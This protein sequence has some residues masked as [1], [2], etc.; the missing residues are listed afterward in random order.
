MQCL[1]TRASC[2]PARGSRL[3][4]GADRG[5]LGNVL[6]AGAVADGNLP[7]LSPGAVVLDALE[8]SV[9]ERDTV[10]VERQADAVLVLG[11]KGIAGE[12]VLARILDHAAKLQVHVDHVGVDTALVQ[13]GTSL[14]VGAE[15]LDGGLRSNIGHDLRAGR[16]GLGG[17]VLAVQVVGRVD[18][19]VVGLNENLLLGGV[20]RASEGNDLLALVGDGVGG[21]DNVSLV[22]LKD[23]LARVGGDL[24]EVELGLVT[25][26]VAGQE[27][28][29]A[30]VE[31]TDLVVLLVEE[32]EERGGAGAANAE[33]A[34]VLDLLAQLLAAMVA[35]SA[36]AP[37]AISAS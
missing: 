24:L 25:Q 20:V 31:A 5:R 14:L 11:A 34:G 35:S 26:D 15:F 23:G 4:L 6:D 8:P 10:G 9:N 2:H 29:E 17:D 7:E 22:V 36:V 28:I 18:V 21:E 27:L 3:R 19:R 16:A 12:A 13:G 37:A 1:R 32:A 33:G 30:S